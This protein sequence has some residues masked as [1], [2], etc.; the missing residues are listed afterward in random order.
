MTNIPF[1]F[2]ALNTTGDP[3]VGGRLFTYASDGVTPAAT[4]TDAAG[5]Y[6]APNPL[7][8]NAQGQVVVFAPSGTLHIDLHDYQDNQMP[9]FPAAITIPTSVG[10]SGITGIGLSATNTEQDFVATSGQKV[11][12][13]SATTYVPGTGN[14]T[15]Y[16]NGIRLRSTA[17]YTET[18]TSTITL[19][20]GATAGDILSLIVSSSSSSTSVN[21]LIYNLS[22]AVNANN[23]AGMV[24][25][26]TNVSYSANTVGG[27]LNTL[28]SNVTTA[29]STADSSTSVANEALANAPLIVNGLPALPNATYPVNK[30]VYDTVTRALYRST[31]TTWESVITPAPNISGTIADAQIAALAASKL[32]GTLVSSQLG[33][34]IIDQTKMAAG[35]TVPVVVNSLPTL[36]SSSYPQG[37]IVTLSTDNKLYR[38]T[39]ST[40]TAAVPSTDITGQVA[41]SQI[42]AVAASKVTG[43]LSDSQLAA[44]SAAKV[45]GQIT[46][47]QITDN[48]IST[49]KIAAGAV[50]AS[51][52]ATDTITANQIAAGAIT[53]SE[54]AA[55]AV[56]AGKIAAG[57]IQA[58]DI[59]SNAIT[60]DKIAANTITASQIATDTITAAQIA[61]GAITASELA[62]GAVIA[63]KIAAGT[64]QAAD[65][66]SNT[67]TAAQIAA[68]TITA[69]QIAADTITS[70]QIAAGAIT[71]SELAAGAVIAGKIA[72]GTIQAGDIAS[73]TITSDKIAANTITS[74][75]IAAN[76]ITA[77][78]I[79]ANTITAGQIAAAAIGAQQIAANAVTA[80]KLETNMALASVIQ[81]S[82]PSYSAGTSSSAPVG[83]KL[84]G[85]SFTTTYLGGATDSTCQM[86]IG[87]S[88]NIAG[89][90]AA[91]IT[92]KLMAPVT[93]TA[94]P[95][96]T[97]SGSGDA[98]AGAALYITPT[99]STRLEMFNNLSVHYS[100][101]SSNYCTVKGYKYGTGTAPTLGAAV[102]GSDPQWGAVITGLTPGTTYWVDMVV[103]NV[104]NNGGDNH[105]AILGGGIY[106][107]EF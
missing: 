99:T 74:A 82:S 66:A 103:N 75:Q 47:T 83:F 43:Q 44:I 2:K 98:M 15:V 105:A 57:T 85:T 100:S 77:S 79:A 5:L 39:G 80:S 71:A 1:I 11:F 76:T 97:Y 27:K 25:Y 20:N 41:D 54:L 30:L 81:S 68:N 50:T 6:L 101:A 8:L 90:K 53:S 45:T 106:V 62:A 26:G 91:V 17:D 65:I 37:S 51:Q 89:Y 48:A 102:T 14:I 4:Y 70:A 40:W 18:N 13:L 84:S 35:L 3:L 29:Q 23:G 42:A 104:I 46:T 64:I 34:N 33:N 60:A 9:Y 86:E 56:V 49:A 61:A 38:S 58:S 36:P 72:A 87:G 32:T 7:I 10:E 21:A 55:G 95:T 96:G 94:N 92:N 22:D 19:V 78:Q 69:G 24:A 59:A 107:T 16:K 52:I 31:G 12:T 63:G 67:I 73:S 88:I 93:S 28:Q